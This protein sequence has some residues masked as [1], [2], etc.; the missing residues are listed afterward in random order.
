MGSWSGSTRLAPRL[1]AMSFSG[2]SSPRPPPHR[3]GRTTPA[4]LSRLGMR[5]PTYDQSQPQMA[6]EGLGK[7]PVSISHSASHAWVSP[8]AT[9]PRPL[10]VGEWLPPSHTRTRTHAHAHAHTHAR[11]RAHTHTR[12]RWPSRAPTAAPT[13]RVGCAHSATHSPTIASPGCGGGSP[14]P[15]GSTCPDRHSRT[16]SRLLGRAPVLPLLHHE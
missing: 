11:A 15:R 5:G 16:C 3:H 6:W 9:R 12:T 2:R 14:V 1:P 7:S 13:F 8:A 4:Y 10:A